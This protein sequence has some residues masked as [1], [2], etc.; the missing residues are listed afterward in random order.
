VNCADEEI[1]KLSERLQ[2]DLQALRGEAAGP[3]PR[4]QPK[5]LGLLGLAGGAAL[6]Y[7]ML[8]LAKKEA[9]LQWTLLSARAFQVL[10]A[11]LR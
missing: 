6:V 5:L 10:S 4:I 11:S 8:P 7:V 3:L 9:I 2:A 1:R